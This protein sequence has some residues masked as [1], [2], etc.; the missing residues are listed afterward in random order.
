[1]SAVLCRCGTYPRIR[2]AVKLAAE[3]AA[4]DGEQT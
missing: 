4:R 3:Y 2:K 1:M